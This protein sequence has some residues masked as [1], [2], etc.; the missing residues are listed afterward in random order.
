MMDLDAIDTAIIRALQEDA[1]AS[2]RAIARKIGVSVPTVSSHVRN[3]EALGLIRGYSVVLDSERLG[4]G[5]LAFV[6]RTR[7]EAAEEVAKRIA[8]RAWARRVLVGRPGWILVD[9]NGESA[10]DARALARYISGLPGVDEVQEYADLKTMK[11]EP[12]LV[13]G[14]RLAANVACFECK[15]PIHGEPVRVRLDDRHHYFCCHTC[16]RLYVEKLGRMK[17]AARKRI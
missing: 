17:A 10:E 13:A 7:P 8:T 1:R 2:L 11:D 15:G 16:E 3:L 14:D 12:S 5:N 4:G 9:A 6:A